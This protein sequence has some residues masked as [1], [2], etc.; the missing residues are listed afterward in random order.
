MGFYGKNYITQNKN[1]FN[2]IGWHFKPKIS[3]LIFSKIFNNHDS[4]DPF[5]FMLDDK[6]NDQLN[7]VKNH[8]KE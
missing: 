6:V 5:G 8:D 7:G 1:N 3:N 4:N 2:D